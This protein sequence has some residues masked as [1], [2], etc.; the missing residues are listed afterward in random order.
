MPPAAPDHAPATRGPAGG[1]TAPLDDRAGVPGLVVRTEALGGSA[2]ARAA[3]AGR[4]PADWYAPTP[5][6][7]AA[8]GDHAAAI[9]RQFSAGAWYELLG[10]AL[11]PRGAAAARLAEVAGGAGVVVTTGQQP[12][13]FGG[14]LYTLGKAISALALAD[15]LQAATGVPVA[16]VFWAATDDTD[17]AEANHTH[18]VARG[19]LVRLA[20]GTDAPE[21]TPMSAVPL[22]P[23]VAALGA[24]LRD[25]AGTAANAPALRDALEA[26]APGATV[27]GAYVTLLRQLLEPLGITVLDASHVAVREGGFQLL[28]RALLVSAAVDDAVR[29]RGAEIAAAGFAPQVPEVAGRSLVFRYA[30]DGRKA[31]VPLDEARALVPRAQRAELG[32]N[33]L[34]RP[35]VERFLLPTAAY[36]AGPGEYAYFAQVSAVARALAVSQPLAVPRWSGTIVEPQVRRALARL[37]ADVHDLADAHALEARLARARTPASA[38]EALAALRDA[39]DGPLD[40]LAA[41]PGALAP[42]A[43]EGARAQLRH[44]VDRLER[45][46]VA[47]AKR[48]D[49]QAARDLEAVRAALRP[50]GAPQERVLNAVPL[51]ARHGPALVEAMLAA[52]RAHAERVVARGTAGF[53]PV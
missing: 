7:P 16:P 19:T 15:A 25:A 24:G 2:L 6:G 29:A 27:G 9:R 10:P 14:P 12:G 17:F 33:V 49:A 21:G 38:R 47:A 31:R 32:P 37:D 11:D 30:G 20:H 43:V 42:R 51:L 26:Y 23:D 46:V 40:A 4:V 5:A 41:V 8:W 35:V 44:K 28:R 52:A 13:L 36:V 18:V 34:L 22:G 39:L 1:V 48:A 45:R 3:L 50:N 53:A